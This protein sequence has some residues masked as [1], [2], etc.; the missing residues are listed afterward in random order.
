MVL[1]SVAIAV[2]V[3]VGIRVTQATVS[4]TTFRKC[5]AIFV[6]QMYLNTSESGTQ[7]AITVA[8]IRS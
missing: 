6:I 2:R 5:V 7:T 4:L 8:T 1:L 3:A